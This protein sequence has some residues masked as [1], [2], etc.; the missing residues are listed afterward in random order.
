MSDDVKHIKTVRTSE[1]V[2]TR[3]GIPYFFGLSNKTVGAKSIAMHL[4][5]IP[6]GALGQ[7][8]YH[9]GFETG[10]YVLEGEVETRYGPRLEHSVINRAGDFVYIP[11]DLV[12]QPRNLSQ[13]ESAKA[14]VVRNDPNE[15]E[16]VVPVNLEKD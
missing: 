10:I 16:N 7:T 11:P 5:E 15:Q 8:H 13:T 4:I 14:I 2:D 1:A 9:K 6:P 3:Q 12:H